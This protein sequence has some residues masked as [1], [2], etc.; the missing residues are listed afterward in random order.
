MGN[1]RSSQTVQQV[2]KRTVIR[3]GYR[4]VFKKTDNGTHLVVTQHTVA[5]KKKIA[6]AGDFTRLTLNIVLAHVEIT[7]PNLRQLD[8]GDM[9]NNQIVFIVAPKLKN[10]RLGL[11]FNKHIVVPACLEVIH[12]GKSYTK[13]LDLYHCRN[14]RVLSMANYV[15]PKLSNTPEIVL[16]DKH[17]TE[18]MT[19]GTGLKMLV[20]GKEY[21][22]NVYLQMSN[23]ESLMLFGVGNK[24]VDLTGLD[25]KQLYCSDSRCYKSLPDGRVRAVRR[26]VK[27]PEQIYSQI[28]KAIQWQTSI[29]IRV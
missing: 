15:I 16:I 22:H 2:S 11:A 18:P 28:F 29:E 6:I 25:I 4:F 1:C 9:F 27:N 20:L 5:P 21:D 14:L 13:R 10:I 8:T 12:I 26:N 7:A 23:V 19:F 17:T 3:D 24:C